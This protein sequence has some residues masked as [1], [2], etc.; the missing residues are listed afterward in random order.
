M[1]TIAS[2]FD[3]KSFQD[4]LQ[5][6]HGISSE[7]DWEFVPSLRTDDGESPSVGF[8]LMDELSR[9][10]FDIDEIDYTRVSVQ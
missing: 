8:C 6:C 1:R 2:G 10:G 4:P 5:S 3:Q 7:G 9:T